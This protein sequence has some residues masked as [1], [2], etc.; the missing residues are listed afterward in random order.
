MPSTKPNTVSAILDFLR[1]HVASS[2]EQRCEVAVATR[3]SSDFRGFKRVTR[4]IGDLA[5]K[6]TIKRENVDGWACVLS[7]PVQSPSEKDLAPSA[8]DEPEH[9]GRSTTCDAEWVARRPRS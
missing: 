8:V 9:R 4:A 3:L 1:V 2:P 6:G 7:L 5:R